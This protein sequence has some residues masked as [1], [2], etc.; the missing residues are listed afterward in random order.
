MEIKKITRGYNNT[1]NYKFEN[2]K[3][4]NIKKYYNLYDIYTYTLYSYY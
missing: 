2:M 3:F 1:I 4:K